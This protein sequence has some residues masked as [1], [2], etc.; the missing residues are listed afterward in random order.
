[1]ALWPKESLMNTMRVKKLAVCSVS[2]TNNCELL[3]IFQV[4]PTLQEESLI[5]IHL[6]ELLTQNA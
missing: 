1:M 6:T 4:L 3:G 2:P 5:I